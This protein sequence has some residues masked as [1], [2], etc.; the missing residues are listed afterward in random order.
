MSVT[1]IAGELVKRNG[2]GAF[3]WTMPVLADRWS[4]AA[5]ATLSETSSCTLEIS[6]GSWLAPLPG[7]LVPA[8]R[9]AAALGLDL[10]LPDGSP[11]AGGGVLVIMPQA[12]RRLEALYAQVVEGRLPTAADP[13]PRPDRPVPRCLHYPTWTG[14]ADT[15]VD[16]TDD[17]G[18]GGSL[19][20]HDT[21]G[22]PI[23]PVAVA[24]VLAALITAHDPLRVPVATGG[25][26]PPAPLADV[27][28]LAGAAV[29][30]VRLMASDGVPAA[31][32]GLTGLSVV[33]AASGLHDLGA[34]RTIAKAALP[35]T[36]TPAETEQRRVLRVGLWPT[37]TLTDSVTVAAPA[38]GVTLTRDMV[39]VRRVDLR[40]TLLGD[41]PAAWEGS[42]R[43]P[44][45]PVRLDEDVTLLVTGNGVAGAIGAAV[46]GST[47]S[48][49]A[50]QDVVAGWAVP[51]SPGS[52]AEWPEFPALGGVTQAAAGAV[53]ATLRGSLAPT[54]AWVAGASPPSVDVVL[55]LAGLP[56]GAAVRV[57]GRR[58]DPLTADVVRSDGAGG[59]ADGTGALRLLLRDPLG[60]TSPTQ[61]TPPRPPVASL[62]L[63][64]VVVKRTRESRS[65][66]DL[67]VAITG[68]AAS[69]PVTAP[70]AGVTR[71]GVSRA[72]I[73]GLGSTR[74]VTLP[75]T[76]AGWALLLLSEAAPR[77]APRLPTLARRELLAAGRMADGSWRAA[78]AA[79][80]AG[81]EL[82]SAQ[83]RRG[84]PGAPG[85]RETQ[86]VGVAAG[87]R[88][89]YDLAR[90]ALRRTTSLPLRLADLAT[91]AWDEPTA[92]STTSGFAAAALQTVSRTCESPELGLLRDVLDPT[93]LG[94][95]SWDAALTLV[96][97]ELDSRIAAT[98]PGMVRDALV[99]AR[100]QLESLR[101]N[102]P[103][104]AARVERLRDEII[105]ELA[106]AAYGR[107]DAQWALASALGMARRHVYIE[108]PGVAGTAAGSDPWAVDVW[109]VLGAR[110]A[111]RPGLHV[112]VCCP[113]RPRVGPGYELFST[114]ELLLRQAA[115]R[116]LPTWSD[117][118]PERSRIVAFH[119]VGY[120]GRPSD[121]ETTLVVVDDQ[122]ALVGASALRRRGLTFDGAS[123]A[124]L[125]EQRTLDG[126]GPRI[127][128]L[129]R[130]A[131][132]A[133]LGVSTPG[134]GIPVT[135]LGGWIALADGVE[136]FH[137]VRQRLRAG[138][139]GT[140]EPVADAGTA[141]PSL[142]DRDLTDPDGE[143]FDAVAGLIA[144]WWAASTTAGA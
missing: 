102:P 99:A 7:V 118:D 73:L 20:V 15:A 8:T 72:G 124:V 111:A 18:C 57:Y 126:I 66:G 3:G 119:P 86:H 94:S 75:T 123:D 91:A 79:G 143:T 43:T 98:S 14:T 67:A 21:S 82:L 37:G 76:A 137:T 95:L 65:F 104:V 141:D 70:L 120:P 36:P 19:T 139:L 50:A 128:D 109:A 101:T 30:R 144:S 108:T 97:D 93:S 35:A 116:A 49:V 42:A 44:A 105:R 45:P 134:P 90:H 64:L 59:V 140:I 32:D 117:N 48:L 113:R 132:A 61:P 107:R 62:H 9:A 40:A 46:T 135:A 74:P 110:M 13:Q 11:T 138:G 24:C 33:D 2:P 16:A 121:L 133:R 58:F 54:A 112:T 80:R 10:V 17:L 29:L 78:L 51:P 136:A 115:L 89:A 83:P 68:E 103:A 12:Y 63:D 92:G 69:P 27:T 6:G 96:R 122:W 31:A 5:G 71:A 22:M 34:A 84:N 1:A 142:P 125:V 26:A 60:L 127:A 56:T 39:S 38:A 55:D 52:V 88:L 53:P 129:R 85:G 25:G 87:G 81:P 47:L 41:P 106:A 77:D 131:M 4:P 114:R 28:A 130:Q 23:D 100:G